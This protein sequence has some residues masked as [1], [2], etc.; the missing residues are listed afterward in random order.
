M[1]NLLPDITHTLYILQ[2][3]VIWLCMEHHTTSHQ[4]LNLAAIFTLNV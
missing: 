3:H 1:P 2:L 4:H